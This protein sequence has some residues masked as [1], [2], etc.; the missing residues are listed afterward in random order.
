MNITDFQKK[1][2]WGVGV[3][4][5]VCLWIAFPFIF[6]L[7]IEAYKFPKDFTD[8]GPFGDIYGS[9]NTLISSIALCAVAYSTYLQITSLNETRVTNKE[10]LKLAEKSHQEQLNE[11]R[12]AIF[13]N[14]F[15]SL[16][17][18]KREKFNSIVLECRNNEYQKEIKKASGLTV[19]QI[20][21]TD[22]VARLSSNPLFFENLSESEI[23]D[24]FFEVGRHLFTD[25]I[26][27]V[28][29]YF[30]IYKNLIN[31]IN[32]S[33]ISAKDKAHFLDVL[34]N[35]MFQ[36]EQMVLFWI[37]PVFPDIKRFIENSYIF[38]QIWY[39]ESLKNYGL[40]FHK[41]KTFRISGWV[42]LFKKNE[43]ENPA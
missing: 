25:S 31:L 27:P 18:Y 39:D 8:F 22:F 12:N 21:T 30:F 10:Q 1:M 37:A 7:L 17:N 11:S 19:M 29:S 35:S 43:S 9:L 24:H 38:N 32:E 33:E 13:A 41:I 42:E 26:S 23:R 4:S 5:I 36:E 14:Q 15:Y 20:L 28:V 16:L 3:L 6:K 40:R 2:I 34:C